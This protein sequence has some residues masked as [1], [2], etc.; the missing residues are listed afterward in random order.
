VERAEIILLC[1]QGLTN[2]QIAET[3]GIRA[4]TAS[5]WR[6]RYSKDRLRGLADSPRSGKPP[7]YD[8][9]LKTRI[10]SNGVSP[11]LNIRK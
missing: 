6:V 4:A 10:L 3:K 1:D 8:D 7:K 11:S 5:K 9:Q 2:E